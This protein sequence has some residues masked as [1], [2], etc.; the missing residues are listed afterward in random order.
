MMAL[1]PSLGREL[2]EQLYH[3]KIEALP[4]MRGLPDEIRMK[5]CMAMKPIKAL[6]TDVVFH[7]GERADSLYVIEGGAVELS[8]NAV[9]LTQLSVGILFFIQNHGFCI[10]H[11][12]SF[13]LKH[14][15]IWEF[16]VSVRGR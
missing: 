4:G 7:E 6:K 10:E 14:G 16:R 8:R 13:V 9:V 12:T 2:V 3:S 11:M 1:P 5:L 15:D